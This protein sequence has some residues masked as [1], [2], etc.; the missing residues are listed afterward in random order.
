MYPKTSKSSRTSRRPA[1]AAEPLERRRLLSAGTL[2][3]TF[4]AGGVAAADLSGSAEDFGR[5]V[6]RQGDGKLVVAGTTRPVSGQQDDFVVVR[7][8]P[9]GTPDA[10]FDGDGHV[11]IDVGAGSPDRGEEVLVLADGRLLVAGTSAGDFA[12]VRLLA[13]GSVDPSFGTGGRATYDF[14]GTDELRDAAL[15]PDGAIVMAGQTTTPGCTFAPT[16]P[17]Q[18]SGVAVARALPN[19]APDPSFGGD[20]TVVL[21]DPN[22]VQR[23]FAVAVQPDGRVIVAGLMASCSRVSIH[24][25]LV[26]LTVT[27]APDPTFTPANPLAAPGPD[28]AVDVAVQPDGKIVVAVDTFVGPARLPARDDAFTV[29]RFNPD[30]SADTTFSGDGVSTALFGEGVN[31]TAAAIA[32]QVDKIVVGGSADGDF[33]LARFNS[34]GSLDPAFGGDGTV[35]TDFGG[36]DVLTALAVQ[37]DGKLVAAGRTGTD[38]ALARYGTGGTTTPTTATTTTTT[39]TSPTVPSPFG[40]ACVV[41]QQLRSRFAADLWLASYVPTVDA[42]RAA[43]RCP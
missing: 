33:A 39:T 23:G 38:V 17:G 13:N 12:L 40:P 15:A 7:Y 6:V 4:G 30:G 2:D 9:D 37:P 16:M 35:V 1:A 21:A 3:P 8:N 10:T 43:L 19:G 20:G 34:D 25:L 32:L 5:A 36:V 29:L 42:A 31:A 27:G 22:L 26:R 18:T 24:F 14:G 11:C 41:L 28:A